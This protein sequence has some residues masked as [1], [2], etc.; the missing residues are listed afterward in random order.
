MKYKLST[1]FLKYMHN[2][3]KKS[4]YK[5]VKE[6]SRLVKIIRLLNSQ[7]PLY[8]FYVKMS[9]SLFHFFPSSYNF[10]C[11]INVQVRNSFQIFDV[12]CLTEKKIT[13]SRINYIL[14]LKI[15]V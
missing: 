11:I 1:R 7:R 14:S 5:K 15:L 4:E 8:V 13:Y 2:I 10:F 3:D 12:I 9:L 6:Q